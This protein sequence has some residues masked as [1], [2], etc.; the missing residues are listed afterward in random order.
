MRRLAVLGLVL[1]A[2]PA[3]VP[4]RAHGDVV[5]TKLRKPGRG[6][7]LRTALFEVVRPEREVCQAV[8]LPIRRPIEVDRISVRMPVSSSYVSHH[9][10]MFLADAAAPDLPFGTPV[11]NVGCAGVGGE[12]VSPILGFVQ[13]AG[14]DV[15]RFPKGVGVTLDPNQ[16]LLFNP[17]VVNIADVPVT[18]DVAVNFR[19]ARKSRVR[20][21]ARSFQLGTVAIAVPPGETGESVAEWRTPFPMSVVWLSTHSHKHTEA[22]IVELLRGA[23]AAGELV[24]T[25]SYDHPDVAYYDVGAL[26]LAPGD[27]LRWTCRYRNDTGRLLT[28]GVTSEDE[29][30]FAVG[31]FVTDDDAPPPDVPGCLGNGLGL[32]CPLN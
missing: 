10:A 31:F 24:H 18:L 25:T 5:R 6:F 7:Q 3:L 30:C 14:G 17:H 21:H 32:V 9:F 1:A 29:M 4:T 26:R 28:F 16:A 2:L 13:R 20:H 23:T 27:G 19:K 15:I 8:A 12:L 11:N 22:A